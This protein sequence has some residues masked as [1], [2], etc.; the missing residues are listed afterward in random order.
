MEQ[1]S[2]NDRDQ[3]ELKIENAHTSEIAQKFVANEEEI[4]VEQIKKLSL[5]SKLV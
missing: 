3:E 4:K 2:A 1:N 5:I